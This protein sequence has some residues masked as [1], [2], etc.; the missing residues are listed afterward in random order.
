MCVR[1]LNVIWKP[2]FFS[3]GFLQHTKNQTISEPKYFQS[4]QILNAFQFRMVQCILFMVPTIQKLNLTSLDCFVWKYFFN[5]SRL[6]DILFLQI[7]SGWEHSYS[8]S[9]LWTGT[10]HLKSEP[11][12]LLNVPNSDGVQFS[13][14]GFE[15]LQYSKWSVFRFPLYFTWMHG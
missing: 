11:T 13:E 14:F 2:V 1:F 5:L 10:D 9:C 12:E 15:P 6:A 4:F 8:Y 3:S 7:S